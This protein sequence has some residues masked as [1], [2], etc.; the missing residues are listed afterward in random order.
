MKDEAG[1]DGIDLIHMLSV[2]YRNWKFMTII[3]LVS[4]LT[5]GLLSVMQKKD[6]WIM[7]NIFP[8]TDKGILEQG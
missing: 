5:T 8:R 3:V 6:V 1:N 4:I 7:G 2:M